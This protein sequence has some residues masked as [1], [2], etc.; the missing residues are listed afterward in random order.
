MMEYTGVVGLMS[1]EQLLEDPALFSRRAGDASTRRKAI[2]GVHLFL[3][4]IEICRQVPTKHLKALKPH[5]HKIFG[6]WLLEHMDIMHRLT[7]KKGMTA[8]TFLRNCETG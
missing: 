3:E 2:D 8:E 5:A 7:W 6:Q 4:Y 1:A